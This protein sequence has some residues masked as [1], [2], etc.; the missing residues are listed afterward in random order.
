MRH[1]LLLS[2]IGLVVILAVLFA[3]PVA[4]QENGPAP[5]GP[6]P[7]SA[8]PASQAALGTSFTYQGFLTTS[9]SPATGQFDF[10]FRMY[11]AATGGGQVGSEKLFDN[12]QVRKGVFTVQLN[13]G[14]DGIDSTVFFG[15][16]RWIEVAVRPGSS[17]GSYTV[18]SPRQELTATP[19]AFSLYPDANVTG[20]VPGGNAVFGTNTA[21]GGESYGL[22]GDSASTSGRGV[23]GQATAASGTTYGLYGQS[24][25]PNGYGV[26]GIHAASSGTTPGV[27]GISNSTAANAF[28][29]VGQVNPASVGGYSTGVRGISKGT[30][31]SGIGVWGSQD[32]SGWGVYGTAVAGYGV[33]GMTTSTSAGRGVY[34]QGF[35]GV[36]G[37]GTRGVDGRSSAGG[38]NSFGVYGEST[39]D[40]GTGVYGKA[41]TGPDAFGVWGVSSSGYAAWFEGKVRVTGNLQKGGGSFIIDH[42]LDPENKYLYHSFVESPDMMNIYNGNVIL[43]SKGEA[44]VDLPDWFGA[45][46]RDFR[47]QLTAIGAPGPNLYIAAPVQNNRFQIA[48]G[49]PG[50]QVSWQVTGIRQDPYANRHR[51]PVEEDK[52]ASEQGTYLH[53]DAYDQPASKGVNY[54]RMQ[55]A[56]QRSAETAPAITQ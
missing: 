26:Y 46:N 34:G 30:G 43:D 1:K 29:V 21:A 15:D 41:N 10:R 4:A 3:S 42:P 32:G 14:P 53:P 36:Y 23:S 5:Q 8:A 28:A 6:Q 22:R 40:R 44:W 51:I 52:P 11:S 48:G 19:Y 18:L 16:A 31:G 9:G 13:Y 24:A 35:T 25:S 2:S 50:A 49:Q 38:V 55:Q 37:V 54:Q 27:A 20:S 56:E 7:N 39:A 45:L 47:Y 17:G 12:V 33:I